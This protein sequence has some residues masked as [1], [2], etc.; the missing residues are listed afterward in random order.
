[1][2][3]DKCEKIREL[4]AA[5]HDDELPC[6]LSYSIQD[7][8]N[9]C[10]VCR[11]F[12]HLELGFDRAV[13]ARVQPVEAP[14]GLYE[15]FRDRLEQA[16]AIPP[17]G[18]G[19]WTRAGRSLYAAAAALLAT[20]MLVPVME[21]YAPGA[22]ESAVGWATGVRRASGVLVCVECSRHGVAIEQQR[23]CQA[24]GHHTG[25]KCVDTG[26]WH[27]VADEKPS[28]LLSDPEMRGRE[29]V[30]E[31]KFLDDIRYVDA[32]SIRLA[33]GRLGDDAR[34]ETP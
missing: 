17:A 25:I 8:L 6:E 19:R 21:L 33:S 7:H 10:G 2:T 4:L 11:G 14:P 26:L 24:Q 29:V 20:V 1:M 3:N 27:V 5:F 12:D 32:R 34:G 16:D 30:V 22:V 31:G 23:Q 28:P 18:R 13:K 15:R 9:Q